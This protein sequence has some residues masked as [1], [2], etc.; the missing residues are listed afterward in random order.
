MYSRKSNTES[1]VIPLDAGF[2]NGRTT[3]LDLWDLVIE[4][5]RSSKSTE[6]PTHGAAGNSS[7]RHKS[8]PKQKGIRDVDELL[9]VDHVVTKACFSLSSSV[10]YFRR[11]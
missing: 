9:N 5:S 3:A 7:R 2:A 4:V 10:V 8:I 1:E 11:Q 6:S